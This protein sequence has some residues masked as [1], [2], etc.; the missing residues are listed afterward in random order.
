MLPFFFYN[1]PFMIVRWSVCVCVTI[2]SELHSQ[3]QFVQYVDTI[4]YEHENRTISKKI[5]YFIHS[6]GTNL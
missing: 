3:T 4:L 5:H 2:T 1:L 6:I